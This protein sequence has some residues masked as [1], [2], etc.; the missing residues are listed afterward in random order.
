M[1]MFKKVQFVLAILF[2]AFSKMFADDARSKSIVTQSKARVISPISLENLE[3][4]GLYFGI[5]A[6]GTFDASILIS[7]TASVS[8]NILTG[9]A[10]LLN[11]SIQT[12]AKFRVS[13]ESGK[14]YAITIPITSLISNGAQT[15]SITDFTCS[16]LSGGTIGTNDEFFVGGTLLIPVT[17]VPG[18]YQGTFNITVAYN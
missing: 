14:T 17:S 11:N 2:I 3:S 7:P 18:A 15:L 1:K 8:P 6:M 13:G 10:I 16:N 4:Q 12:A 5:I 9:D